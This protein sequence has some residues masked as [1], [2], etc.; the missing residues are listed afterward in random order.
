M[1]DLAAAVTADVVAQLAH[2]LPY[3]LGLLAAVV[4]GVEVGVALSLRD[5]GRARRRV[6]ATS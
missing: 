1:R 3:K 4:A 6:E 5:H 2:A